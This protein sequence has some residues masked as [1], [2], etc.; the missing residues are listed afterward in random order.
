MRGIYW[1]CHSLRS[2][3]QILLAAAL[4]HSRPFRVLV[5]LTRLPTYVV[6][7][8][9]ILV[10]PSIPRYI[11]QN[12]RTVGHTVANNILGP[13]ACARR[14][15]V[16]NAPPKCCTQPRNESSDALTCCVSTVVTTCGEH[17]APRPPF[18]R[19]RET[20]TLLRTILVPLW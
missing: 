9:P 20:L 7:V 3:L 18:T 6:L 15:R 10:E 13:R 11:G 12:T 5:S 17:M 4:L 8:G 19:R 16:L 1:Y 14:G 2:L